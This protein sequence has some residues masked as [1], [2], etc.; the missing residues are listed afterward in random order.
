MTGSLAFEARRHFTINGRQRTL[1][2][3]DEVLPTEVLG[4]RSERRALGVGSVMCLFRR[5]T[6]LNEV[7]K[8]HVAL[9]R[10][11]RSVQRALNVTRLAGGGWRLMI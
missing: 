9:D 2:I 3:P 7:T 1:S 10:E 5:G 11:S 8:R 4:V 6:S